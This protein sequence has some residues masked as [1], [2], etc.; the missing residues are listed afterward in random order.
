MQGRQAEHLNALAKMRT[1]AEAAEAACAAAERQCA[2]TGGAPPPQTDASAPALHPVRATHQAALPCVMLGLLSQVTWEAAAAAPQGCHDRAAA[3]ALPY[4][5][6]GAGVAAEIEAGAVTRT[7]WGSLIRGPCLL[8]PPDEAGVDGGRR[9]H[10]P[11]L[12]PD[13]EGGGCAVDV[14]CAQVTRLLKH[15]HLGVC[16]A[17]FRQAF[18]AT[19]ALAH[20]AAAPPPG[21]MMWAEAGSSMPGPPASRAPPAVAFPAAPPCSS[22]RST[23]RPVAALAAGRTAVKPPGVGE[24]RPGAGDWHRAPAGV[25]PGVWERIAPPQAM[26][27][28][29]MRFGPPP[30]AAWH[31]PS[32]LFLGTGSSEPSKYR[33]PSAILLQVRHLSTFPTSALAR[34]RV[35]PYARMHESYIDT[36]TWTR[37][38]GSWKAGADRADVSF[39]PPP[40]SL[41][42]PT[43]WQVSTASTHDACIPQGCW[44][45]ARAL[46]RALWHDLM[47]SSAC[48]TAGGRWKERCAAGCAAGL[49]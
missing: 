47:H 34:N 16:L 13:P 23:L 27:E 33:G 19:R 28:A 35:A 42:A 15:R 1:T 2:V 31:G 6:A 9:L 45:G 32:L 40:P 4:A 26:H 20:A 37:R 46:C 12:M 48:D 39:R 14:S 36:D 22:A 3:A 30:P 8:P 49:R 43:W 7:R 21:V 44:Y 11:S 41:P 18:A 25:D 10:R 29:V 24:S 5:T 38:H 17:A